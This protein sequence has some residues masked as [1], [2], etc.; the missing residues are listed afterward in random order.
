MMIIFDEVGKG[1]EGS[2]QEKWELD[3]LFQ[4]LKEVAGVLQPALAL[5]LSFY[6]S[7]M[8][9]RNQ[10]YREFTGS[11]KGGMVSYNL[12]LAAQVPQAKHELLRKTSLRWSLCIWEDVFD[13]LRLSPDD[14]VKGQGVDELVSRGLLLRE[15]ASFLLENMTGK[16]YGM[17]IVTWLL[18]L[19]KE[20]YSR[21]LIS[22]NM[23]AMLHEMCLKIRGSY[24]DC[25]TLASQQ[26]PYIA[27]QFLNV[28]VNAVTTIDAIKTGIQLGGSIQVMK[29]A[30][31]TMFFANLFSPGLSLVLTPLFFYGALELGGKLDNPMLDGYNKNIH[32]IARHS[33]H[34][35]NRDNIEG[36]NKVAQW[37]LAPGST[38]TKCFEEGKSS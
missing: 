8:I 18:G 15:E 26:Y 38:F 31:W 27:V 1:D 16:T 24:G 9:S 30:T 32:G 12:I 5:F 22:D 21:N 23:Q 4:Q 35:V 19:S 10:S 13:K 2:K 33:D 28:I 36:L 11:L 34:Q 3:H 25:L 6:V 7:F 20:L 29:G 14:Y 17:S 37:Q